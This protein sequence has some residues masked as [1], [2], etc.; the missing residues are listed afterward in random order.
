MTDNNNQTANNT[1]DWK[2]REIGALWKREGQKQ[3]YLSGKMTVDGKVVN[4]VIF[5]NKFKEKDNQPDFRVY[6]DRPREEGSSQN[7]KPSSKQEMDEDL[8]AVLQ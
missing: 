2:E 5:V 4:V 3:R 1:N 7:P 8:P 6:E